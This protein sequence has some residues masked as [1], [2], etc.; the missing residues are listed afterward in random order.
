LR[1]ARLRQAD[2]RNQGAGGVSASDDI[3]QKVTARRVDYG[4]PCSGEP[5]WKDASG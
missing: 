4:L 3:I 1:F 2:L 5:I